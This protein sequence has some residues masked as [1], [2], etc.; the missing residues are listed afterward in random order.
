MA[1]NDLV[2]EIAELLGIQK[3]EMEEKIAQF[4]TDLNIDGRFLNVRRKYMGYKSLVSG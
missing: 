2:D 4:Y 3:E 1:F